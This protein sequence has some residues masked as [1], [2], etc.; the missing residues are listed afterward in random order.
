MQLRNGKV[1]KSIGID[2]SVYKLIDWV[3]KNQDNLYVVYPLAEC[4]LTI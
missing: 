2:N 4:L 1:V 3:E